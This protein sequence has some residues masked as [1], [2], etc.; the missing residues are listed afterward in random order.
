MKSNGTPRSP[1]IKEKSAALP[2]LLCCE[3]HAKLGFAARRIKTN[4]TGI[5][6]IPRL[7]RRGERAHDSKVALAVD[8][9]VRDRNANGRATAV[10]RAARADRRVLSHETNGR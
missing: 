10:G 6:L 8:E 3:A 1:K 9:R 5:F 2:A 4:Q 7:V